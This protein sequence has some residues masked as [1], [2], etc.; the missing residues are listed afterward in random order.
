[1]GHRK[2]QLWSAR[3]QRGRS[4]TAE[5]GLAAHCASLQPAV[6]R[7]LAF[8]V[9]PRCDKIGTFGSLGSQRSVT[10]RYFEWRMVDTLLMTVKYSFGEELDKFNKRMRLCTKLVGAKWK[11]PTFSR[12]VWFFCDHSP[13][14][15]LNHSSTPSIYITMNYTF[16]RPSVRYILHGMETR[17]DENSRPVS[18]FRYTKSRFYGNDII[19][20]NEKD[21]LCC[22]LSKKKGFSKFRDECA[23]KIWKKYFLSR[24]NLGCQ[25]A[26]SQSGPSFDFCIKI[27]SRTS[28]KPRSQTSDTYFYPFRYSTRYTIRLMRISDG[29][30]FGIE[31]RLW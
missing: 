25:I 1:M 21:P 22:A 2:A 27:L 10:C 28:F 9:T 24:G 16:V 6:S 23:E 3:P 18:R 17:N 7:V 30:V 11:Q 15:V 20:R 31:E 12:K 26:L 5:F 13:I 14:S 8:S 4:K 29:H 19:L